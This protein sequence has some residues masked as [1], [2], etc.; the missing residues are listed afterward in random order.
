MMKD[1]D[2]NDVLDLPAPQKPPIALRI[3]H[4]TA[5]HEY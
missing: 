1:C 4:E 5:R 2:G 3:R